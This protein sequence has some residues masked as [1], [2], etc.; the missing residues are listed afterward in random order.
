VPGE[1]LNQAVQAVT[2]FRQEMLESINDPDAWGPA[3]T[4]AI[5][6]Q[7]AGVNLTDPEAL[8]TFIEMYNHGLAA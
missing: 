3:K 4:F 7:A 2:Q 6:A 5:A 1:P 8:N